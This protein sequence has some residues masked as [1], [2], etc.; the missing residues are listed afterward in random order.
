MENA[1][2]NSMNTISKE[3]FKKLFL[4]YTVGK[5]NKGV[6]GKKRLQKIVYIIERESEIK[7]FEF[8]KYLYGQFSESMDDMQDYL[9]SMGY[10][11]ASPL[12]TTSSDH[13]GNLFE[14]ADKKLIQYYSSF[15][16]NINAK[17]IKRID[18]IINNYGYLPESELT[19]I[20]Y[21]FSEFALA[22]WDSILFK[23]ELPNRI[24]I[25][26]IDEDD[27]EELEISLNPRFINL[28]NRMDNVFE[29]D[30]FDPQK[31]KK[32]VELI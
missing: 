16:E 24:A 3:T 26:N 6:F 32:V 21:A 12:K 23:E 29:Q 13:S 25:K 20:A 18:T 14:L 17:L 19:K 28:I 22:G 8:K 31:V 4:L 2:N 30:E 1:E 9:L 15:M 27:I 10:L 11:I 5:F 7:P